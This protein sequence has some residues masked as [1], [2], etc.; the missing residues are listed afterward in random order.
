MD[1]LGA[2]IDDK[3]SLDHWRRHASCT[4]LPR[5]V[6]GAGESPAIR[7]LRPGARTAEGHTRSDTLY[8]ASSSSPSRP[9][10]RYLPTLIGEGEMTDSRPHLWTLCEHVDLFPVPLF[11]RAYA[12]NT[13]KKV[14]K[15]HIV[16]ALPKTED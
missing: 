11:A 10:R 13:R 3:C 4:D 5:L 12:P 14:H 2:F 8:Q 7:T 6:R 1:V 15:V 16:H 9:G